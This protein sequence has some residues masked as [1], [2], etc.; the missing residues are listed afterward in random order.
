MYLNFIINATG[1]T[2]RSK[3]TYTPTHNEATPPPLVL[4]G[5]KDVT[6]KC[7]L[8]NGSNLP[9]DAYALTPKTLTLLSPPAGDFVLECEVEIHP[10]SNTELM[11]LYLSNGLFCSQ[12]EPDGFRAI[13]YF[14]DRPDVM[15]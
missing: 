11:G 9:S 10:E 14:Y 4:D 5:R 15:S 13:T 6:L 8:L 2:V 12:C 7:L 1:T 3:V